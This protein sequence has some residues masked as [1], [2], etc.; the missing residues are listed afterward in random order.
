MSQNQSQNLSERLRIL[1]ARKNGVHSS[2]IPDVPSARVC[3]RASRLVARAE[4][5]RVVISRRHIR[6]YSDPA[7]ADVMRE[8]LRLQSHGRV[9]YVDHLPQPNALWP[10]DAVAIVPDH[11]KVQVCPSFTPRFVECVTPFVHGFRYA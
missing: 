7:V 1:A 5:H 2:D 4:L 3:D 8:R 10:A 6:Y 11:V 9:T